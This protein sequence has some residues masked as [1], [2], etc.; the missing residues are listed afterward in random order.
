MSTVTMRRVAE[1]AASL[2]LT[3]CAVPQSYVVLLGNEDGTVGKVS[4]T[5]SKGSTLLE[6]AQEATFVAAD[7]GTSFDA[8]SEQIQK[9]F[10]A[11]LTASP[12]KPARF[13]LY[14]QAGGANLTPQSEIELARVRAEVGARE[15]PDISI[16]GHTDTMGESDVNEQLG[17]ERARQVSAFLAGLN[18]PADKVAV[19]SH[20]EKNLLV[21]T[22][23]NTDEPRN[24]R[25]EINVR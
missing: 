10:G 8:T 12:R 2:V 4:V 16:I 9:D 14:F 7:A 22:P 3:G 17:M 11:A 13:L 6:R 21:A 18:L 15:A 1:I 19:E 25:V 5:G 20:G 24:R 23:D